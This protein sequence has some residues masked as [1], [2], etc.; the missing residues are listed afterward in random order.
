MVKSGT[1]KPVYFKCNTLQFKIE[2]SHIQIVFFTCRLFQFRVMKRWP[3]ISKWIKSLK[4]GVSVENFRLLQHQQSLVKEGRET[5]AEVVEASVPEERVGHLICLRLRLKL[6][7][8]DGSFIYTDTRTLVGFNNIPQKG[9]WLKIRYRP[10]NLMSI[11][12]L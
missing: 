5:I 10:D 1:G 3:V 2:S 4:Q 6:R 7:E 12:L 9:Q 8:I 11:L